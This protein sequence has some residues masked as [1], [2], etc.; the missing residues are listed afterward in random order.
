MLVG[1]AWAA[2]RRTRAD[3]VLLAWVVPYFLLVTLEPAK[4][5]RYSAPLLV[6]LAILAGRLGLELLKLWPGLPRAGLVAVAAAAV[7]FT[8]SYDAAYAGLFSTRDAR[9]A[10]VAWV[11]A[12]A[13]PGQGVAFEE[14]PDGIL[15]MPYFLRGNLRACFL[16]QQI[17]RLNGAHYV[18]LDSYAR[19]EL[20][21]HANAENEQ[22]RA[23]LAASPD[24]RKVAMIDDQPT[25]LGLRFP[26]GG[27]PHD[28]RYPSHQITI[29]ERIAGAA[30]PSPY[31]FSSTSASLQRAG[32]ALYIP[33]AL[34]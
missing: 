9:S 3:L 17:T 14:L 34:R 29:Y 20:S 33:P 31:C 12:R 32:R 24:F 30:V 27:S 6:P 8:A 19:E 4:F 22:L 21:S 18:L 15:T 28:W 10:A 2:I 25:F 11:N 1:V 5:M 16:Q 26:I 13:A 23:S 7:A